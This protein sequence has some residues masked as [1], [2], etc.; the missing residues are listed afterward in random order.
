MRQVSLIAFLCAG[1][2]LAAGR[3][4]AQEPEPAP[5]SPPPAVAASAPAAVG[6][7]GFGA[8][9]VWVFTFQ[10]ADNGS[11][12]AFVHK[13]SGGNTSVSLNPAVDYFLAPNISLGANLSVSHSTGNGTNVGGGVRVGYNLDIVQNVGFWPTA[14]FFV[15][16][17]GSAHTTNTSIGVLAPFIWHA[18]THFFLGGGP[19]L[20][21]YLSNGGATEYGLDFMLGGWL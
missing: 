8:P 7:S 19:D 3:A 10:T 4:Y 16:H 13:T 2:V 11:G 14:R 6:S 1:V 9:G 12:Y 5:A 15:E 17:S 18:T 20:N 21:R